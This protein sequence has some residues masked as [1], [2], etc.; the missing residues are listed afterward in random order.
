M[1]QVRGGQGRGQEATELRHLPRADCIAADEGFGKCLS[2]Y[3]VTHPLHLG[4]ALI[5][6]L[7]ASPGAGPDRC[8]A[9]DR[10]G[11]WFCRGAAA[12]GG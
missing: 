3:L 8:V 5:S 10:G 11:A 9:P 1:W 2:P 6:A 7:T 4:I 12:A